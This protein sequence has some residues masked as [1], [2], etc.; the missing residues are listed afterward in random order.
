MRLGAL[1]TCSDELSM[2]IAEQTP[3]WNL[4]SVA[5]NYLEIMLKHRSALESSF[6]RT[7]DDRERLSQLLKESP[8]VQT[9][10]PSG[11]NFLLIRLSADPVGADD[12]ARRLVAEHGILVKDA[13]TKIDDGHGY[14]RVAVRTEEDHARLMAA[15]DAIL[16]AP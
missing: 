1:L 7:V 11:G 15:L 8:L 9:V 12:L 6:V 10:F 2:R 3:I 13:S 16:A 5:E 4:S 14:W